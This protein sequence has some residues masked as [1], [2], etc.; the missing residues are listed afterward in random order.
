MGYVKSDGNGGGMG[1]MRQRADGGWDFVDVPTTMAARN[2]AAINENNARAREVAQRSL[3]NAKADDLAGR[4]ARDREI[5]LQKPKSL[6]AQ[7]RAQVMEMEGGQVKNSDGSTTIFEGR[8]QLAN[9]YAGPQPSTYGNPN[10]MGFNPIIRRDGTTRALTA[11]EVNAQNEAAGGNLIWDQGNHNFL[12]NLFS[13]PFRAVA[14]VVESVV[15]T[16]PQLVADVLTIPTDAAGTVAGQF[17]T[18]AGRAI[19]RAPTENPL[20]RAAGYIPPKTGSTG[21]SRNTQGTRAGVPERS[22]WDTFS[23]AIQGK[24]GTTTQIASAPTPAPYSP[25]TGMSPQERAN[26]AGR[27]NLTS[28]QRADI[29]R[30]Q[31]ASTPTAADMFNPAWIAS[32]QTGTPLAPMP[33][34]RP[35]PKPQ[36]YKPMTTIDQPSPPSLED[37]PFVM[38]KNTPSTKIIPPVKPAALP[39]KPVAAKPIA[40]RPLFTPLPALAPQRPVTD[41]V[42]LGPQPK[43]PFTKTTPNT[44]RI[45]T[46][47]SAWDN[48]ATSAADNDAAMSALWQAQQT[49]QFQVPDVSV[50][51]P[52]PSPI[53]QMAP[54]PRH[55]N[56]YVQTPQI[57]QQQPAAPVASYAGTTPSMP[58]T[59]TPLVACPGGAP[60]NAQ[61]FCAGPLYT[62]AGNSTTA[63][64]YQ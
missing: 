20:T 42:G 56:T 51:Q 61:G 4:T 15:K 45:A 24:D 62:G 57:Y 21:Q 60:R 44:P 37:R 9:P 29:A 46:N 18:D 58:S 3:Q 8:G 40:Y 41:T 59:P 16:A 36:L 49:G 52:G 1:E 26:I 63:N 23:D 32:R 50:M 27:R 30:A 11:G 48:W 7:Y 2:Q 19:S 54:Q 14:Q 31:A 33:V 35:L 12:T 17:S 28:Q 5:L 47:T 53:Q 55:P 38:Y 22:F 10:S 6:E 34:A 39:I 25:Y 64:R 43:L 13:L